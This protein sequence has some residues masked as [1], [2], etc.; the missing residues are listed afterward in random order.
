[1][2]N[3]YH[4]SYPQFFKISTFFFHRPLWNRNPHSDWK[5]HTFPQISPMIKMMMKIRF[6]FF[7]KKE[8]NGGAL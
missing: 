6:L 4:L 5:K 8:E 7:L 3:F 1:M 2:D